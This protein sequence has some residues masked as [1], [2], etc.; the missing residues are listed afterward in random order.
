MLHQSEKQRVKMLQRESETYLSESREAGERGKIPFKAMQYV[1]IIQVSV[2]E[3]EGD[4]GEGEREMK[5]AR[6]M[7]WRKC[8][9]FG[10]P[11][12]NCQLKT[13]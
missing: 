6:Q 11:S 12:T 7:V 13:R 8:V 4:I 10:G 5:E 9:G 1:R 2:V 3:L